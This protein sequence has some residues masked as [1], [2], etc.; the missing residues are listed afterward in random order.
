MAGV[1]RATIGNIVQAL[2]DAGLIEE[3]EPRRL[4]GR[5]GKPARP[6]W[7]T[8]KAG[9]SGAAAIGRGTVD[10]ALANARGELL[11]RAQTE[12]D[13]AD[14]EGVA[15]VEAVCAGL[16]K[17]LP[18][19]TSELLGIGIA[20]PGVCDTSR[21]R[22]L[23][24]GQVPGLR[25]TTLVDAVHKQFQSPVLVDNDS[26][27]QALGEKWFGEGRGRDTFASIQTGHGLGVGLVLNGV[28]YRGDRGETG[29]LGHT[30]VVVGGERCRC[31]L[32]GCWETIA[33]LR[34]LR[35]EAAKRELA[36]AS[37]MD[38]KSLVALASEGSTEARDLLRTYAD[39]L[40]VGLA[41]LTQLIKPQLLILHG[42]AVGGGEEFRAMI[43][44]RTRSRSL[45]Y[46]RPSV[47]VAL[48]HL[49]QDAGLLGTVGLVLSETF[50]RSA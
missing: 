48:S 18:R 31:G 5:V 21:G 41:N 15:V 10:L 24:S 11:E 49:D 28:V 9:L 20:V 29:E 40:A 39:N 19:R 33:T 30:C 32:K 17:V 13:P 7:F 23:A 22:I 42:D 37:R 46:L 8:A 27:A 26:R 45:Q 2:M 34:W 50:N 43:E 35:G 6:L 1:T 16:K 4:A 25:G 44:D 14:P 38:A 3:D 47:K 12:F 36:H